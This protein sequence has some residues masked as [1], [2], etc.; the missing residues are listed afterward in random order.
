QG[1]LHRVFLRRGDGGSRQA[2]RDGRAGPLPEL[3]QPVPDDAAAGGRPPAQRMSQDPCGPARPPGETPGAFFLG[4]APAEGGPAMSA[5]PPFPP[6]TAETAA[7]K[8][9]A[10]EDGWN[11]CAPERVSLAYT[12]AGRWRDRDTFLNG[13][14]DIVACLRQ[15]WAREL[16]YRLIKEVWT[17]GE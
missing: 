10:A 1:G 9:R 16:E 14:A 3:H 13:R 4:Y 12:P 8:A 11:T 2:Q 7:Q 17:H 15:K 6:F 5:R